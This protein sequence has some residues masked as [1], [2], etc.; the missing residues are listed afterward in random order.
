VYYNLNKEKIFKKLHFKHEIILGMS[1][2]ISAEGV[3]R[4]FVKMRYRFRDE[5]VIGTKHE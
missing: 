3:C 2:K 5:T 1:I 4:S